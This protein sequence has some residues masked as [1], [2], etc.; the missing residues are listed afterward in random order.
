M[1][2]ICCLFILAYWDLKTK[3]IYEP[4]LFCL[5]ISLTC[6]TTPF[7]RG[8]LTAAAV[9]WALFLV[10]VLLCSLFKAALPMGM[11]DIRLLSVLAVGTG[12][13]GLLRIVCAASLLSGIV[14][15]AGILTKR[16]GPGDEMP[17]VPFIFA[18]Y[19]FFLCT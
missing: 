3:E 6:R 17:F 12:L 14:S 18:G 11:G 19:L 13:V 4:V 7:P 16:L 8:G 2:Q 9:L 15:A 10:S 5:L 1:F